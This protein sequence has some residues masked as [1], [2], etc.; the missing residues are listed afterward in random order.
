MRTK[1]TLLLLSIVFLMVVMLTGCKGQEQNHKEEIIHK[2]AMPMEQEKPPLAK[3]IPDTKPGLDESD[4]F[5][6]GINGTM[7]WL[8]YVMS[9]EIV[10]AE[11]SGSDVTPNGKYVQVILTYISD[12]DGLGGFLF[13]D[14]S[15]KSDFLLTDS[16][17]NVYEHLGMFSP[18]S[19]NISD[20]TFKI[21]EIQEISGVF[22]DV[23]LDTQLKDLT[24]SIKG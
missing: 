12:D 15:D 10:E 14:L 3:D 20:G 22:F 17:G 13:D 5:E 9:I 2:Q 4:D 21:S 19:I 24:F 7:K 6:D 1:K 11:P 18:I 8:S 16:S 23:P